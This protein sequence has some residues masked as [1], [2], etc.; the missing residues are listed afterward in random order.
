MEAQT[1]HDASGPP[2]KDPGQALPDAGSSL[3]APQVSVPA[4][5]VPDVPSGTAHKPNLVLGGEKQDL[6]DLTTTLPERQVISHNADADKSTQYG[7]SVSACHVERSSC[8]GGAAVAPLTVAGFASS[9]VAAALPHVA[10]PSAE[11]GFAATPS[12]MVHFS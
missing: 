5:P 11:S 10:H 2:R 4:L 8:H 1:V 7:T 12:I 6:I 9:V 3:E